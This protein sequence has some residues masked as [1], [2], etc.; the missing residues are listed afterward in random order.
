MKPVGSFSYKEWQEDRFVGLY[1]V[2]RG[3]EDVAPYGKPDPHR[4]GTN[5]YTFCGASRTSPPTGNPIR[6]EWGQ[7]VTPFA[8]RRGRRPLREI[9]SAPNGGKTVIPFVG[10]G[11]APAA[12]LK[13][14]RELYFLRVLFRVFDLLREDPCA[15]VN[16]S[17]CVCHRAKESFQKQRQSDCRAEILL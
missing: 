12:L 5:G 2:L 16:V 1:R 9:R 17:E 8:G 15:F 3:V 4:T 14:K 13:P 11:L 6:T 7:T 10:R